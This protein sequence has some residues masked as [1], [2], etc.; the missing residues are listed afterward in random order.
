MTSLDRSLLFGAGLPLILAIVFVADR[1]GAF[2]RDVFP[3]AWRKGAALLLL[4]LVLVVTALLPAASG[5]RATDVST[6]SFSHVL[7]VQ[8]VLAGFLL[9]WWL[10]S[11][12]PPLASFLGL[13]SRRP[14]AEA[15]AGVAL[16]LIGWTLT[17]VVALAA[18]LLFH[19]LNYDPH[20]AVPPLV[21]WLAARPAAQRGLLVLTAMTLE[22]FHF[23]SFL[24]RR[25]GAVPASIFFL[26]A[27]A[28][29]GEPFFFVGLLAIT[30]VLAV[31]FA[32]T[33]NA[34]ASILA[35]GTFDAI[36]L[37]IFLP[38]ALKLLAGS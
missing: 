13:D 16:G 38:V 1:K 2:R 8:A 26:L 28:G 10:L 3:S 18:A 24:Q 6:L 11:G 19:V 36:Q 15:G 33:G 21:G 37:F 23:R 20:Q 22:E 34:V 35:H 12:R 5:S 7:A 14:V 32:K 27:H 30:T 4:V 17:I 31:A 29:Y 25:L 9:G